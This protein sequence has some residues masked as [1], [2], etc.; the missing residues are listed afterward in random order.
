MRIRIALLVTASLLAVSTTTAR[1]QAIYPEDGWWWDATTPGRGYLLERQDDIT[2]ITSFHYT[3]DGAPEWLGMVTGYTPA[4][5][6]ESFIG[7]L[8][9]YVFRADGGQCIGCDYVAPVESD[10]SQGPVTITFHTNR[11]A[12]LEWANET[13]EITRYFFRFANTLE[14]LE[15]HW[16][17][18][19]LA[20]GDDPVSSIVTVSLDGDA[21]NVHDQ[22]GE[23]LGAFLLD[24]GDLV[25][26][27]IDLEADLP[28][29]VPET[30]RFYAGQK[31]GDS[32][33]VLGLKIDDLPWSGGSADGSSTE[34][35]WLINTNGETA[36]IIRGENGSPV[37][38]DVQ[39]VTS[40]RINGEE[41]VT[42][43]ASGIPSYAVTIT[44]DGIS[45]LN[46]R[47]RAAT[48]FA[49]GRTTALA[50]DT[51]R[52]GEDIGFNSSTRGVCKTTGGYGYWPP[53]PDCP[54]D[55]AK[56][57]NFPAEPEPG[58]ADCD[59]GLG[60]I[61]YFV[62]GVS[63]FNWGD[64]SSYNNQQVW[65]PRAARAEY[66][67]V[68][69]C[70]GHAANGEYHHHFY[71]QCLADAV[72][73]TADG[74]SPVYGFAADGYAIYGPWY[75]K[76][77]LARS[78]WVARDYDDPADP[79]GCGGTGART[80]VMVD[81]Y[82]PSKGTTAAPSNGPS[83]N[84]EIISMSGNAFTATTGFYYEDFY[85]DPALTASGPEYLD[86]HGGHDH[87]DLGYHYHLPTQ[88]DSDGKLVTAFPD[89]IGPRFFGEVTDAGISH[90]GGGGGPAP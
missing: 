52:F 38:V 65:H 2:F 84:T 20:P 89:T 12:T 66:Y 10:S 80:C 73:D 24:E 36:A 46:A 77:V 6:S 62:N 82:N 45:E 48:D 63:V 44:Q 37:L 28:V 42:V 81:E 75:A 40:T 78:A 83:T 22:D 23:Y 53:G 57:G 33:A 41:Y 43:S 90:C 34:S 16:L 15:G 51:I 39:S 71:S 7:T 88:A 86:A 8:N 31:G 4:D 68:D 59:T 19:R 3:P 72:G 21:A 25:L 49:T 1:A 11:S 58:A 14:Q 76:G 50:G 70:H 54:Q 55:T 9:G 85:Y 64:G 13:I 26:S 87:G 32:D 56:T 47:P 27:L 74:H 79:Y 18:A 30:R 17:L 69:I 29:L 60:V 5:E 35:V 67:D 61:G